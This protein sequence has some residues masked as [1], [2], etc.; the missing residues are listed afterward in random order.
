MTEIN[1]KQVITSN[2]G[3]LRSAR[4][5]ID[6]SACNSCGLCGELC[7]FGLPKLNSSGKYE[8]ERPD[9]CIE[10]SACQRNCP[11]KAI[12]MQEKTGCGCM[13][14][15]R[16]RLKVAKTGKVKAESCCGGGSVESNTSCSN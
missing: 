6:V 3:A 16:Q 13:W 5:Y 12:K 4:I 8:I 15:A 11:T 9:L 14:D 1:L 10:C 2:L 7:P